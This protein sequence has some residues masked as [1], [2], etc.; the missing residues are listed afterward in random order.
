[1]LLTGFLLLIYVLLTLWII[2]HHRPRRGFSQGTLFLWNA[3]WSSD[4]SGIR[5]RHNTAAD[6]DA[7][8]GP[9]TKA[10]G[11]SLMMYALILSTKPAPAKIRVVH[12]RSS[13]GIFSSGRSRARGNGKLYAS[14]FGGT[15]YNHTRRWTN[16]A[17]SVVRLV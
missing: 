14:C 12:C 2:R 5:G 7:L 16:T 17:M 3:G 15:T 4:V 1:M 11:S 8:I 9:C 10:K 13:Y 6:V